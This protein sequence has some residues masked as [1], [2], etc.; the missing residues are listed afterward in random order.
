MS[1]ETQKQT[2]K[3]QTRDNK[4]PKNVRSYTFQIKEHTTCETLKTITL[5]VYLRGFKEK[6]L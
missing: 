1:N 4:T 3:K 6:D 2:N 5:A